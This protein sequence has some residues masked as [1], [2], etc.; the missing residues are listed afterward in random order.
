[1]QY[2][3]VI[4]AI[5]YEK[6][7]AYRLESKTLFVDVTYVEYHKESTKNLLSDFIKVMGYT[8]NMQTSIYFYILKTEI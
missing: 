1:M 8:V 5:R 6:E 4:P 3:N 7:N 2:K